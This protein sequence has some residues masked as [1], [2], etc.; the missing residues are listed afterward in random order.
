MR[1]L[2]T[3][4]SISAIKTVGCKNCGGNYHLRRNYDNKSDFVEIPQCLPGPSMK[5][6]NY[7]TAYHCLCLTAFSKNILA[8]V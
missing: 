5:E 8:T 3:L 6:G 4:L 2:C 7:S 1:P